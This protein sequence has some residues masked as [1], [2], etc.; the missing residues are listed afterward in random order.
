MAIVGAAA[1]YPRA[2]QS[3]ATIDG[4]AAAEAQGALVFHAGTRN[5]G[6]D[7]WRVEGGRVISV[8]GRGPDLA[9]ARDAAERAADAISWPGMQR[10]RDIAAR[11]PAPAIGAAR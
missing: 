6:G 3:G 11:L 10:R 1:G 4:I 7:R 8:V 5:D 2:P 9:A